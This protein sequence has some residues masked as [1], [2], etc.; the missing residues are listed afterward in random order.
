M[1]TKTSRTFRI[2]WI[3]NGELRQTTITTKYVLLSPLNY[4][5]YVNDS[6][7]DAHV[8]VFK[9]TIKANGETKDRNCQSI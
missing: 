5:E 2:F 1:T 9:A 8:K 3:T 7:P 4:L 6:N